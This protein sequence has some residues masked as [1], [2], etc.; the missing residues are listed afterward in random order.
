[1]NL[2]TYIAKTAQLGIDRGAL[3]SEFP[4]ECVGVLGYD[5]HEGAVDYSKP[6]K[7][8]P[9]PLTEDLSRL[10]PPARGQ[11]GPN[12]RKAW[13]AQCRPETRPIYEAW[14]ARGTSARQLARHASVH[15][16]T[17]V[18]MI[19]GRGVSQANQARIL[20]VLTPHERDLVTCFRAV[21][22]LKQNT[23]KKTKL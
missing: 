23:V 5:V 1:M 3:K 10:N 12:A 19:T 7:V 11:G 8:T 14:D 2:E 22:N 13:L 17:V 15:H 4:A 21:G 9:P 18:R 20:A 6:M 16:E